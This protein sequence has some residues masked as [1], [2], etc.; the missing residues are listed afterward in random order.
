MTGTFINVATVLLGTLVGTLAGSRLPPSVQQRVL[1]GLG[2]VTL[3]LGVDL[4]L[5]WRQTSPLYVLGGVLLGGLVGEAIG[6]EARLQRL[7]DR[8]QA[9][10]VGANERSTVSEAF[11]TA[12][13][14]FCVGPLT[15]V[16][17][18][19]DGLTGDYEALA[20]KALLDGF[21]AVAIAASLGPGV[22]WSALTI[23]IVQGGISLGAGAFDSI[24]AEGSEALAALT[25]AGGIL[26]IGIAL[27]LLDVKDVKVGNFLPAL[28]IAP[29]LVG[30]ASAVQ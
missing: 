6:I 2:L 26:I 18:I 4:A 12:S 23:L 8:L 5:S 7:G 24:L 22:A 16:G 13:L 9:R 3:V 10:T 28:V 30:L 14:L 21:A 19:Q 27:K 20:T 11:F 25:S 29:A 1:A 15:I 17:A